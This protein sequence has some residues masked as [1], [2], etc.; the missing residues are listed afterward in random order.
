M[1]PPASRTAMLLLRRLENAHRR[2]PQPSDSRFFCSCCTLHGEG[3]T[4]RVKGR[5]NA[6]QGCLGNAGRVD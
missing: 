5:Q 6:D 4:P 2:S 3:E 1:M